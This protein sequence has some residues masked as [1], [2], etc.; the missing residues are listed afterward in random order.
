MTLPGICLL[1]LRGD[2]LGKEYLNDL[3]VAN[4]NNEYLYD[5]ELSDDR[6]KL[7]LEGDLVDKIANDMRNL[8]MWL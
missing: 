6:T 3:L 7:D 4:Y 1:A 2:A 5:F 8:K